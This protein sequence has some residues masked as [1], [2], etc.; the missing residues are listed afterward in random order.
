MVL[1]NA[2]FRLAAQLK[3]YIQL[4]ASRQSKDA[5]ACTAADP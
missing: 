3:L 5:A 2:A 1:L 4:S